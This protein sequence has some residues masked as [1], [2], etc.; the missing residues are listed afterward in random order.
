MLQILM[1]VVEGTV[2]AVKQRRHSTT[3]EITL[4]T[5]GVVVV[6][7]CVE[8]IR[9]VVE[10]HLHLLLAVQEEE[11]RLHLI[12]LQATMKRMEA[13]IARLQLQP[14]H[15]MLTVSSLIN[16]LSYP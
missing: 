10:D 1:V 7:E 5:V 12:Q 8:D 11:E 13:T 16:P 6:V 4:S 9:L 14:I 15:T 2:A 3:E